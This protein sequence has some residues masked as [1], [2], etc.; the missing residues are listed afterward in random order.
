[1]VRLAAAGDAEQLAALNEAF[2]GP[3]EATAEHVAES[4]Q[5]NRQEIVV[6][7]EEGAELAGFVC[8]QLRRSFCYENPAAEITEVYVKPA[9]RGRGI[10]ERM[11]AFAEAY[12]AGNW[13]ISE[14]VLLT[15]EN[16][17]AAQSVYRRL[18]YAQD[19]KLHFTK[20]LRG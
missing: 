17:R 18:G 19:R 13:P 1:M 16:N 8:V 4:L 15:G 7:A 2:N 5:D 20:R 3:G 10:A 9:F 11:I 6:V 14:F 12:C